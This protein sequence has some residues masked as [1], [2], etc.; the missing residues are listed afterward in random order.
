MA[1]RMQALVGSQRRLLLDISHELRSPLTRLGLAVELARS[2]SDQTAALDRI[3]KEADR[4]NALVG[5]VLT[6]TRAEADP[7][8]MRHGPVPV[9]ELLRELVEICSV[10]AG[11]R[12]TRLELQEPPAITI[13]GDEELLRRAIENVIRNA[14][15]YEPEG[16]AIELSLDKEA[17]SLV[18]RIRDHGPGAPESSLP[19][20]FEPFY[21]VEGDRSRQS[22][23]TGLGLAIARRAVELHQ[24]S[25]TARNAQPGLL[26]EIRLPADT[27]Q[28]VARI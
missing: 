13:R 8:S 5:E 19:H 10:E 25:I 9:D 20:L 24:G 21:R 14:I 4:L 28:P 17:S 6:L 15:R 26:I 16:G 7:A 12:N 3:Q 27:A 22:G 2:G 1:E 23:G 11:A 18:I